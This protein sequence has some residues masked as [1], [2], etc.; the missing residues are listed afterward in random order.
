VDLIAPTEVR[1]ASGRLVDCPLHHASGRG[2]RCASVNLIDLA[3]A[4]CSLRMCQSSGAEN[5]APGIAGDGLGGGN[6]PKE[7]G[8]AAAKHLRSTGIHR[9]LDQYRSCMAN[10]GQQEVAH[11]RSAPMRASL[12]KARYCGDRLA[13]YKDEPSAGCS[14]MPIEFDHDGVS[15]DP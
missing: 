4:T 6:Q 8:Q 7:R 5:R 15:F 9:Q 11:A 12:R 1:R 3:H 2:T 14:M 10:H 13:E